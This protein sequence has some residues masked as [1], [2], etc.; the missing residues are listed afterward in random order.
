MPSSTRVS[1]LRAT[2]G[3]V[4]R[5]SENPPP[6]GSEVDRCVEVPVGPET[7]VAAVGALGEE[8]LAFVS[9]HDARIVDDEKSRS[10][11]TSVP[12]RQAGRRI[13]PVSRAVVHDERLH[14][15]SRRTT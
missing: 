7:A 8:S 15:A 10:A 14:L 5:F 3:D 9:P 13:R 2:P 1:R 4:V 6:A 12:F 11:T